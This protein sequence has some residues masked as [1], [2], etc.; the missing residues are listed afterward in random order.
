MGVK[1]NREYKDIVQDLAVALR[2][3]QDGYEAFEMTAE[4]WQ[5]QDE[6]EQAEFMKTLADD[7]FYGLGKL[8]VMEI[9]SGKIEYDATN[10][11]I[12]VYSDDKVVHVVQLI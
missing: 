10:H 4:D 1:F 7:I 6:A 12:K 11:I 9:G 2:A 5:S 3:I 8:S